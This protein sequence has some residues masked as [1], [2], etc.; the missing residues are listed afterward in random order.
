MAWPSTLRWADRST[1]PRCS[2][3]GWVRGTPYLTAVLCPGV[4]CSPTRPAPPRLGRLHPAPPRPAPPG[5][6]GTRPHD[7]LHRRA[8]GQT[9]VIGPLSVAVR[10]GALVGPQERSSVSSVSSACVR[11][12]F[13]ESAV[14]REVPRSVRP[15]FR[16][17]VCHPAHRLPHSGRGPSVK[18]KVN[19]TKLQTQG[20][21]ASSSC[22]HRTKCLNQVRH[23]S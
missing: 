17:S 22:T 3:S 10:C 2:G 9:V 8:D 14:G 13:S 7:P 1:V 15:S 19:T 21:L 23:S 18:R 11:E 20:S 6:T 12:S 5:S 16:P 4:S